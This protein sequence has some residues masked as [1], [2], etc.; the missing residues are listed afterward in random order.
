MYSLYPGGVL[1]LL[2]A[3]LSEP[4]VFQLHSIHQAECLVHLNLFFFKSLERY[5]LH[6]FA[7]VIRY[8]FATTGSVF[9]V[10]ADN[11]LILKQ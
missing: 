11:H 10:F 7:D 6:A 4:A 5:L 8:I 2:R 9:D 1:L 3:S